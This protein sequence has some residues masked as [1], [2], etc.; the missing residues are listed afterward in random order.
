MNLTDK[1]LAKWDKM[2]TS[3]VLLQVRHH[4]EEYLVRSNMEYYFDLPVEKMKS[5]SKEQ[6]KILNDMFEFLSVAIDAMEKH[7]FDMS[8]QIE[9][10]EM[11]IVGLGMEM[12][13]LYGYKS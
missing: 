12:H 5:V 11:S 13:K 7:I 6:W 4:T 1:Q 3:E 10:M 9:A 2:T 8:E